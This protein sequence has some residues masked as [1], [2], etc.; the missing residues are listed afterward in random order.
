MADERPRLREFLQVFPVELEGRKV[1]ALIDNQGYS[2]G[3]LFLSPGALPILTLLNG[4]NTVVDIQAHVM[5]ATGHM[6]LSNNINHLVDS[7]DEYLLL[8]NDRFSAHVTGL[9]HEFAAL[10]SRPAIHAGQGYPDTSEELGR[11]LDGFFLEEKGGPCPIAGARSGDPPVA[12]ISPHIGLNLGGPTFAHAIKPLA[13]AR[14]PEMVV[15]L[16]TCHEHLDHHIALTAKDFDTPFGPVATDAEFVDSLVKSCGEELMEGEFSHRKEHTI[17]FQ[18]L[19][20]KRYLPETL[21]IPVLCSFGAED[22]AAWR[23]QTDRFCETLQG[24]ASSSGKRVAYLASV[25]LAHIGPRYGD[26]FRPSQATV[27]E[28]LGADRKL[29]DVVAAGDAVSFLKLLLKDGNSR[30]V[31]GL[32]PIYAML[33]VM[34][35]RCQGALLHHAYAYMDE[36]TKSFVTFCAMSFG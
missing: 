21:M 13:D 17:E 26:N 15:V 14:H 12:V 9:K 28:H 22:P 19:F 31:C 3:P 11:F 35:G 32:A 30:K 29:L 23:E 33:K 10:A 6:I 24:L 7:L 1:L 34:D 27:N 2:P 8:D 20:I 5:R 16:G 4:E 25:D 18:A 36:E